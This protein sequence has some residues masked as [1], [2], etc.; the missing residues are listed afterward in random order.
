MSIEI[1]GITLVG[2][3]IEADFTAIVSNDDRRDNKIQGA[4]ETSQFPTATFVL[5]EPADFGTIPDGAE[6]VSV[7]ATGD[8]TVHGITNSIEM[9]LEARLVDG[10]IV[11]IGS[12]EIV[13]ADYDVEA[14]SAVIVLS[15]E[16][17]GQIELQLFFT[18]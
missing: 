15:V 6:S 9:P 17:R 4:L 3:T 12:T 18:R 13:F 11:V 7:T 14:P 16:D 1:E 10:V 5:T 8:L 2:A